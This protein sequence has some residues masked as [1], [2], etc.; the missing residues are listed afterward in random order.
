MRSTYI[1]GKLR[2]AVALATLAILV[3][4]GCGEQ[5]GVTGGPP[6]SISAAR[7]D[8]QAS[9]FAKAVFDRSTAIDNK[10]FP[11]TP[12][13]QLRY[14]GSSVEDGQR[15]HHRVVFTITDLTK[16]IDGVETV[17]AWDR[18]YTTGELV[19]EEL[20]FFAQDNGGNVWHLGQYPEVY[21]NGRLV[22]TPAWITGV[23]GARARV[24]VR[25]DPR[26]GSSDYSQGFAPKPI[27]WIDRARVYKTGAHT[28]VPAGCFDD[29]III[30]EF[31]LDK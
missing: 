8:V 6:T 25:A 12:G 31:E 1:I 7:R 17:V 3:T 18:D 2:P 27:N 30:E 5:S 26:L 28:C 4:P 29:V 13:T 21:E 9:D 23:E 22:E 16:V 10:W 19:E 15:L 11:L 20:V 24:F 14:I